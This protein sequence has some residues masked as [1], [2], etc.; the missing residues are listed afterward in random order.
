[1]CGF[2]AFFSFSNIKINLAEFVEIN[3]EI[4]HRGPDDE[5]Y[6]LSNGGSE[7]KIYGGPDTPKE[8][9]LNKDFFHL[10]DTTIINKNIYFKYA[11]GHR[12]LA[13]CD[14]SSASH[15]PYFEKNNDLVLIFNGEIYNYEDFKKELIQK[16]IPL[17]SNG[18]TEILY[19]IFSE[20]YFQC[21]SKLNGMFSFIFFDK[22]KK[23]IFAVR[24][25]FG[26]KPLYYYIHENKF[27][28]FAS[29]IK[30]FLKLKCFNR[31]INKNTLKDFLKY[32]QI[33]NSYET[34][35]SDIKQIESGTQVEFDIAQDNSIKIFKKK[36][37]Q[38]SFNRRVEN[39]NYL[40]EFENLITD[41]VKLRI[42][43]EVKFGVC[44]SGG[45]DSSLIAL[46]S[47]QILKNKV[48]TL[49]FK[50]LV[51]K[52]NEEKYYYSMI[53]KYNFEK[54]YSVEINSENFFKNFS[55][56]IYCQ[57]QPFSNGSIIS[58]N[59]L[60][61]MAKKHNFKV[62]LDGHGSDEVFLGY[63][64]IKLFILKNHFIK[65]NIFSSI[66]FLFKNFSNFYPL[67]M[68]K[69]KSKF[70]S[71]VDT[72]I[73]YT[74]YDL[75]KKMKLYDFNNYILTLMQTNLSKQLT[76]VD[77]N[78]M[79]H[80]IE[81]RSPFLD[82]RVVDFV[83]NLPYEYLFNGI[84]QKRIIKDTF[85]NKLPETIIKRKDKIGY[86]N[87][88]LSWINS[89]IIDFYEKILE[90]GKNNIDFVDYDFLLKTFK[91][92]KNKKITKYFKYIVMAEW[93]KLYSPKS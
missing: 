66:N 45:I 49:H 85:L 25:R 50:S 75:E 42:P 60:Y 41:S 61:K 6:F 40:E 39:K 44:L 70:E 32:D 2:S 92:E 84:E 73:N 79:S 58:E 26:V 17:N 28:F 13:I 3:N 87:E 57:D 48:S 65:N 59:F 93:F 5:G 38:I 90:Y 36:F 30:Q 20:Q 34:V 77:R 10:P 82:Y 29:E 55:E 83:T 31:A 7:N 11:I 19:K 51:S 9:F 18:D 14:L 67:V 68:K 63:E 47:N 33:E 27:I 12:R 37:Y 76:M 86:G 91:N 1:M 15:Q 46:L 56:I 62:V 52:Y 21:L 81:N 53:N 69:I 78:S 43:K 35:F 16:N 71:F 24:D 22:K 8:I 23:K 72:N 89:D 88:E 54:N 80:S 4:R 74:N 64:N